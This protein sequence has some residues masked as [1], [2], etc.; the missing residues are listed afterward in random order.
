MQATFL[1]IDGARE[2]YW[3]QLLGEA[4]ASYGTLHVK[5]AED[6]IPFVRQAHTE[7]IIID[8][9]AI[10]DVPG[11]IARLRA[12][13]LDPKIVVVT[14]SPTWTRARSAFR[15]GALE[16]IRKSL[17]ILELRATFENI[18]VARLWS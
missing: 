14:A 18:L 5:T 8:A 11:L 15:A 9:T 12:E 4:L 13:R 1:L 16:Y 3:P 17:N 7:L 2:H 10:E 6:A